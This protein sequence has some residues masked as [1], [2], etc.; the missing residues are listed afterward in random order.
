M[1]MHNSKTET[2]AA[3]GII[4]KMKSTPAIAVGLF[5][6]FL[7]LLTLCRQ[8]T[9]TGDLIIVSDFGNDLALLPGIITQIQIRG[10]ASGAT[11][12]VQSATATTIR[13]FAVLHPQ[14]AL[15]A[16]YTAVSSSL[17]VVGYRID[18]AD[19]GEFQMLKLSTATLL[20][21]Q[22]QASS[23]D[24]YLL[25]V[26]G[27]GLGYATVDRA[28]Y[29]A[30]DSRVNVDSITT[31]SYTIATAP[32]G[33]AVAS[34]YGEWRTLTT[35]PANFSLPGGLSVAVAETG[36]VRTSARPRLMVSKRDKVPSTFSDPGGAHVSLNTYIVVNIEPSDASVGSLSAGEFALTMSLPYALTL[37]AMSPPS[38]TPSQLRWEILSTSSTTPAWLRLA[39]TADA[40]A[41]TVG[42][43]WAPGEVAPTAS[44]GGRSHV[45]VFG[46]FAQ[47]T[48]VQTL[49][50][51]LPL[52]SGASAG[53]KTV[54]KFHSVGIA[55]PD[56]AP[57]LSIAT[58][59]TENSRMRLTAI[60][61]GLTTVPPMHTIVAMDAENSVQGYTLEVDPTRAFVAGT[62]TIHTQ[63][64]DVITSAIASGWRI[65]ALRC[66]DAY[67]GDC[68]TV[69]AIDTT[70]TAS[71]LRSF[72]IPCTL[73]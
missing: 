18:R 38:P 35:S 45:W 29:S 3:H 64:T 39:S 41:G 27:T 28:V 2:H 59:P 22:D 7:I 60:A 53:D 31:G 37:A 66:A 20:L 16:P 43:Q 19:G 48:G 72:D 21:T 24:V 54:I 56:I 55:S 61:K 69:R 44:Q 23:Q 73:R 30:I 12:T 49:G 57:S 68:E 42:G 4:L 25:K 52:T 32:R 47:Q 1:R 8:C 26:D 34:G 11:I 58:T 33:G 70:S 5:S 63:N 71:Q 40:S 36:A 46:L 50:E 62:L 51:W 15:P 6:T 9:A 67:E 17:G 14:P 13:I 10:E 65:V